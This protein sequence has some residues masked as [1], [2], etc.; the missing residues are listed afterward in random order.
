MNSGITK[1]EALRCEIPLCLFSLRDLTGFHVVGLVRYWTVRMAQELAIA[2]I[3]VRVATEGAQGSSFA[4]EEA[5]A[6]ADIRVGLMED[7]AD[8][9]GESLNMPER[10]ADAHSRVLEA[11]KI[12]G[13]ASKTE[14]SAVV[15]YGEL[16]DL[17]T[18]RLSFSELAAYC[19]VQTL[20]DTKRK[21]RTMFGVASYSHGKDPGGDDV[22]IRHMQ[23]AEESVN[24]LVRKGYLLRNELSDT[25][26]VV[27][28]HRVRDE[29]AREW[30]GSHYMTGGNQ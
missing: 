16:L 24:E 20:G 17:C 4:T 6:Y 11:M 5:R 27:A 29:D 25:R 12:A 2:R 30:I 19:A 26:F 21:H 1:L 22:P 7:L 10:F 18:R 13:W 3:A 8:W 14:R 28:Y 9:G 15:N 23:E